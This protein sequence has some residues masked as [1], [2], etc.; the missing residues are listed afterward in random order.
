MGLLDERTLKDL[1][2][3][4]LDEAE[5]MLEQWESIL[6]SLSKEGADQK[7]L[8]QELKMLA[9]SFKG[10]GKAVNFDDISSFGHHLETLLIDLADHKV[11]LTPGVVELLLTCNDTLRSDVRALSHDHSLRFDHS[12]L[13]GR[14][15]DPLANPENSGRPTPIPVQMGSTTPTVVSN[16]DSIRVPMKRIDD[17]LNAFG[18]QVILLSSL[19]HCKDDLEQNRDEIFRT[20]FNLK[21]LAFDMQQATMTLRTVNLRGLFAK[22]ERVAHDTATATGKQVQFSISG[23]DIEL[24]KAIVDQLSNPLT[25]LIRNAIDHGI[26]TPSD[27]TAAGK[28]TPAQVTISATREGGSFVI[29]IADNGY[30]MDPEVLRQKAVERG[31]ISAEQSLTTTESL[32]LI[33]ENGFTTQKE[34]TEISGRGVGMS[35][36]REMV[37]SLKGTCEIESHKGQGSRFRLKLPLSLSLFNGLL[38]EVSGERF[39]VPSSQVSEIVNAANHEFVKVGQYQQA[40][41]LRESVLDVLELP[42]LLNIATKTAMEKTSDNAIKNR[43]GVI[44]VTDSAGQRV[45]VRV[46]RIIGLYRI[47]QKPLSPEMAVCPGASGVTILGDGSPAFILDLVTLLPAKTS[48]TLTQRAA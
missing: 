24:D 35:V 29:V 41:R 48:S 15:L 47:V 22:L 10:S 40:I 2:Q 33:F 11:S 6:L 7:A 21:K 39:V 28:I 23:A 9:H 18:E 31:L 25:H 46:T 20:I 43:R 19:D 12:I 37:K 45:G 30:G 36:V 17:L 8:L 3:A 34:V 38:V 14:L 5:E 13:L 16:N 44:L 1:R 42:S 4:F 27:R 26:E 32:N